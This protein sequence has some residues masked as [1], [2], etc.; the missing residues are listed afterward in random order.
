MRKALA[1]D[2]GGTRIKSG[3]VSSTGEVLTQAAEPTP[4][5]LPAMRAFLRK[6]DA[7][8]VAGIGV[9]C[10]GIVNPSTTVIES[11]P[12]TLN[13]MEGLSLASL[14]P[15]GLMVR[16]DN[17]ARVAMAGEMMW[18]A[19]RGRRN[20]LM[21]TLGTGVGGAVLAEGHL[22]RGAGGIAGHAGHLTVDPNGPPC[23]C[24]NRGCLETYFSAPAIEAAAHASVRRGVPTC[25]TMDST[26]KDIFNAA[27]EGDGVAKIVT[28]QAIRILG[29]TLAG[30]IHL[31][32]PEVIILGGQITD[33]GPQL[34]KPLRAEFGWRTRLMLRR[35]VP[36]V[37]PKVTSSIAGAAAL[38]F[39]VG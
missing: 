28:S 5:S 19:A 31:L 26:C 15:A 22:V 11:L 29:A 13:Y 37:L 2:I 8:G 35:T 33:A 38:V 32:D 1:I 14:F 30:L 4:A 10:K 20:A 7:S 27:A 36:V 6:L 21:L 23:I 39:G 18:G 24:G 16:A 3:L 25:L 12:G 9:G 17:D 34:L